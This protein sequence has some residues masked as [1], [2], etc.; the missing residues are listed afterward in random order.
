MRW[1]ALVSQ[2]V[3]QVKQVAKLEEIKVSHPN[4]RAAKYFTREFNSFSFVRFRFTE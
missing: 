1:C 2:E 4:N 3:E